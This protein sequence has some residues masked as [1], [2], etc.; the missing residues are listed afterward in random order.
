MSEKKVYK[1]PKNRVGYVSKTK[2]GKNK[3]TVEQD[4]TLKAGQTLIFNTPSEN[5]DSL[6]KGG[7]ISEDQGEERKAKVPEWK[8]FEVDLLPDRD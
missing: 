5:I 8:K 7:F 2:S 1:Q 6:V 4:F 3:I